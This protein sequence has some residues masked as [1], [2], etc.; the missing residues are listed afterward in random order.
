MKA[1]DPDRMR[2]S[3]EE[4]HHEEDEDNVGLNCKGCLFAKQKAS[5]CELASEAA[6]RQGLRDCDAVDIFGQVVIYVKYRERQRELIGETNDEL[7]TN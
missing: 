5:V 3:Q 6:K 4:R 2:F 1:L 7:E